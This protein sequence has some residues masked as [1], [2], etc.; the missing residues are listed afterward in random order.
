MTWRVDRIQLDKR[1][2]DLN[3]EC[4]ELFAPSGRVCSRAPKDPSRWVEDADWNK[5]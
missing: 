5:K 2:R 4:A 1:I 3:K